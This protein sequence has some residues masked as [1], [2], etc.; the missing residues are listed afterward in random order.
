MLTTRNN[1]TLFLSL[2]TSI[3]S[4]ASPPPLNHILSSVSFAYLFPSRSLVSPAPS[5]FFSFLSL[6]PTPPH[7]AKHNHLSNSSSE[8]A[9]LRPNPKGTRTERSAVRAERTEQRRQQWSQVAVQPPG[10]IPIR[11]EQGTAVVVRANV[12]AS[13]RPSERTVYE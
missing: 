9:P 3:Y 7:S 13:T 6:S 1:L 5:H 8:G 2:Y 10:S 12:R 4:T 11:A